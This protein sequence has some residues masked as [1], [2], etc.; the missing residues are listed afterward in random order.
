MDEEWE[1]GDLKEVD[2]CVKDVIGREIEYMWLDEDGEE[3]W[4]K[5]RVLGMGENGLFNVE[6]E[7]VEGDEDDDWECEVLAE[8]LMDDYAKRDL[9]F[10]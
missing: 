7:P 5:G 8:P 4:Y 1:N 6:Y 2:L 3:V 9:R 10:V